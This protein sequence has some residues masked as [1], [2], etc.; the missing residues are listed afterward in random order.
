[1]FAD[2]VERCAV[3]LNERVIQRLA[4]EIGPLHTLPYADRLIDMLVA[5]AVDSELLRQ[6]SVTEILRVLRPGGTAL[7][8]AEGQLGETEQL[9]QWARDGGASDVITGSADFGG[10]I[11]FFSPPLAGTD[12]WSHWEKGPDNNPVSTDEIIQAPYMTQFM[13]G[14]FYIGM[15]SITTAA[16]GRTFLAVGHIAHHRR[17]WDIL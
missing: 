3:K 12:D 1:M 13:T 15:P 7:L 4:V 2:V 17:E 8:R 9:A 16:G 14:P 11:Q 5:P 6:L 10:W